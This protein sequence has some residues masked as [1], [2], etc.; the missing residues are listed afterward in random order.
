MQPQVLHRRLVEGAGCHGALS[1]CQAGAYESIVTRTPRLSSRTAT[2]Q[3]R[4]HQSC[5]VAQVYGASGCGPNGFEYKRVQ[6]GA[7]HLLQVFADQYAGW[8]SG[9][10][11][12]CCWPL[13]GR[14]T[15]LRAERCMAN[16]NCVTAHEKSICQM[17]VITSCDLY[18]GI[19]AGQPGLEGFRELG[20]ECVL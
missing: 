16:G 1:P 5:Q 13:N 3:R 8:C 2:A 15:F 10:D 6:R 7:A 19:K 12:V 4:S 20:W 18:S 14:G 17:R 11:V 9:S